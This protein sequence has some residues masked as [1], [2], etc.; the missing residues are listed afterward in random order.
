MRIFEDAPHGLPAFCRCCPPLGARLA[1]VRCDFSA[2][3]LRGR[4]GVA[5]AVALARRGCRG[6]QFGHS[7]R[8]GGAAC[9]RKRAAG[10]LA[11]AGSPLADGEWQK[12][13]WLVD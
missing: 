10:W 4:H 3:S 13:L 7:S 6:A 11:L 5:M 1:A 12:S 2:A 8:A 9:A